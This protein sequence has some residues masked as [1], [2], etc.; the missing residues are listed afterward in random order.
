MISDETQIQIFAY[1]P[2]PHG[3][4]VTKDNRKNPKYHVVVAIRRRQTQKLSRR[5]II[6]N[7]LKWF[8]Y[9]SPR[10][11]FLSFS[12]DYLRPTYLHTYSTLVTNNGLQLVAV[13]NFTAS[14]STPLPP[15]QQQRCRWRQRAE[16]SR[17]AEIFVY[18]H[19]FCYL[20]VENAKQKDSLFHQP[21]A[22]WLA[23]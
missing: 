20:N 22:F 19:C 2:M 10:L 3:K 7:I 4:R 14:P 11:Q 8:F 6:F 13:L 9:R 15:L 23:Y 18:K 12:L 17:I 16:K 5:K 1:W 21:I